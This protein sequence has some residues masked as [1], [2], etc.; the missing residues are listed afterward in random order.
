MLGVGIG[1]FLLVIL[2]LVVL[3]VGWGILTY[4]AL[5]ALRNQLQNAWAQIDV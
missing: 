3:L 4:N 5:V 2:G 1:L